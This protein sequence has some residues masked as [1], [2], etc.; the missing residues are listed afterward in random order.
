MAVMG[1]D[2][3]IDWT[4]HT[5]N[6]WQGCTKTSF[7]GCR[8]CYMYREKRRY[9]QDP[10]RVTRSRPSTFR[11]PIARVGTAHHGPYKWQSGERVFLGSWMDF[12]HEAADEWRAEVRAIIEQRPD[13]TF[14]ILTKRGER[15]ADPK[16]F[17][18][19]WLE[20]N[21]HVWV[22]HSASTQNEVFEAV[23]YLMG[24]NPSVRFLS[25]EPLLESIVVPLRLDQ[26]GR[27]VTQL[28]GLWSEDDGII[29]WVIVGCESGPRRRSMKLDWAWDI[30]RQCQQY[31]SSTAVFAKQMVLEPDGRVIHSPA[32]HLWPDWAV[33]QY[34]EVE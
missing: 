10:A 12:C 19:G 5:W 11:K 34:P 13:L 17:P 16:V 20:D 23:D 6:P 18:E 4:H 27:D 30:I 26:D 9:G 1:T 31:H 29:H 7:E 25:L 8:L 14:E 2:S 3:A 28:P 15:L 21:P 24:I 22:G 33:R 32:H